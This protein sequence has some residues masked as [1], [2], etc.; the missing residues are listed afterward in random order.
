MNIHNQVRREMT[1][2]KKIIC[3]VPTFNEEGKIGKLV[4]KAPKNI[5]DLFLVVDDGSDDR[6]AIEARENGAQVLSLPQRRGVG[7]A[8]RAGI[9]FAIE[10]GFD[11]IVIMAGNGKDDPTEI[12][13][14]YTPIIEGDSD[15]VQGSRFLPG[16]RWDNLPVFRYV[17]IRVYA[18]L[19]RSLT[20]FPFT[21][22]LN[23][24]RAYRVSIF[25]DRRINIWQSWL[26]Q[27]E[28]ETYLHYK[29]IKLG[30]RLKEVPVSKI[31]PSEKK[32][33]YTKIRPFIDWWKIA[34]PLLYLILGIRR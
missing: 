12:P 9:D 26:D 14:L 28:F 23:G 7:A 6:T 2:G 32:S 33:K 24:F 25:N 10:K 31:Y 16:G 21:D 4:N 17:V 15:Y 20:G 5:V 19:L 18:L 8:I 30:Y 27:Y 3:I 11:I 34:R 1:A 29:V 22:A 13:R